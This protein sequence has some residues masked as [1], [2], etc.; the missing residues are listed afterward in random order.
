M[1]AAA[2]HRVLCCA[3]LLF[4]LE[5]ISGCVQSKDT[6]SKDVPFPARPELAQADCPRAEV[7]KPIPQA[8]L[9]FPRFRLAQARLPKMLPSSSR[10]PRRA[11][12]TEYFA[13]ARAACLG[14]PTR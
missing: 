5:A 7:G 10:K 2:W 1:S 8:K 13:L 6:Q 14:Q 9:H 12:D 11:C 3:T 4:L